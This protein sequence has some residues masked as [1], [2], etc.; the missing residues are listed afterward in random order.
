VLFVI[1]WFVDGALTPYGLRPLAAALAILIV[2]SRLAGISL[3]AT[4]QVAAWNRAGQLEPARFLGGCTVIATAAAFILLTPL[5]HRVAAPCVIAPREAEPIFV[6]TAGKLAMGN[7]ARVR[8]GDHVT[9]DQVVAVLENHAIDREI[10]RLEGEVHHQTI[11]VEGLRRQHSGA[12]GTAAQLSSARATLADLEQQLKQR[13]RDRDL[14][15]VRSPR[16]GVLLPP[17]SDAARPADSLPSEGP[18]LDPRNAAMYLESGTLV[19]TVAT[20]GQF[21]ALLV[22]DQTDIPYVQTGQHVRL[23]LPE[24]GAGV[25]TGAVSEVATRRLEYSPPPLLATQR[26]PSRVGEDGQVQPLRTV[27]EVRV[28]LSE[29]PEF[30]AIDSTGESRIEVGTMT[31]GRRLLRWFEATFARDR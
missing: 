29:T 12:S 11:L 18:P 4:R 6:S 27:Y 14:L 13:V 21:D 8:Y 17:S 7:D 22:V 9:A 24:S 30:L 2:G 1:L 23:Q 26:L 28:E 25:L 20:Q 31:L 10:S 5:P 16:V 3:G 15:I 19:G